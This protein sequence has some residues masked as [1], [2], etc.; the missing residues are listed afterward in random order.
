MTIHAITS[1]SNSKMSRAR[2]RSP[3]WAAFDLKQRQKQGLEPE[4]K[5][6]PYP[7]IPKKI[8][9][10]VPSENSVLE[11]GLSRRSF[12]S[13]LQT[14][15]DFSILVDKSDSKRELLIGDSSRRLSNEVVKGN[16][17]IPDTVKLKEL[18]GWADDSLIE[19][20]LAAV[21]NDLGQASNVLKAIVSTSSSQDNK[22]IGLSHESSTLG[23]SFHVYN[24]NKVEGGSPIEETM[25]LTK[26]RSVL[27]NGICVNKT[28]HVAENA[29]FESK[30]SDADK[31]IKLIS[32]HLM[33][34]PAEPEWEEEDVYLSH[35]KDAI[36][37]VRLASQHSKASSNSFLKGDHFSAQQLSLKAREEWRLAEELN[38]KV[39]EEILKIR[40]SQNDMWKLD[41]HGLHASEAVHFLHEHLQKIETQMPLK[42]SLSPKRVKPEKGIMRS[43][44]LE[45]VN[46]MGMEWQVDKHQALSSHRQTVLQVITGTGNHSRGQ[47]ALPAAVRSFLIENGYRFDETRPGVIAAR[48]KFRHG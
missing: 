32:R 4:Y 6:D 17:I 25:D 10:V 22:T 44:S 16:N 23:E 1:S 3:G 37:M 15:V 11:K 19:D 13:V 20:I 14:S 46:C 30:L 2:G 18:H 35:R 12:S 47:A 8:N 34:V 39:A 28:E 29:P 36:R 9:S 24:K 38:M 21:N 7:P 31:Q 45:S 42:R 33:S 27:E 43:P 5:T 26:L 41:L 40:N 48:P